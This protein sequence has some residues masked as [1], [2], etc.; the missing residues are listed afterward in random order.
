VLA[1]VKS[2]NSPN[3]RW[4]LITAVS[5][6]IAVLA[7]SVFKM[8][9]SIAKERRYEPISEPKEIAGWAKGCFELLDQSRD[10][11]APLTSGDVRLT[12]FRVVY[13]AQGREPTSLEQ[14]IEY[15]GGTGGRAGRVVPVRTG[16]IGVCARWGQALYAD[17]EAE[18]IEGFRDEMVRQW[19][20]TKEEA[21]Q[22]SPDR[23]SFFAL[24]IQ[25]REDGPVLAV[26]FLDSKE[27][28]FFQ[29][30]TIQEAVIQQCGVLTQIIRTCY[31]S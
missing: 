2:Y 9:R 10:G 4:M 23:W 5:L 7:V 12:V 11:K 1:A 31:S 18:D 17:R 29:N 21:R 16:L 15:V 25:E 6:V 26:V 13:D 27:K 3:D 28:A 8:R 30:D 20:Y 14:L 22:L 24:P 19:G